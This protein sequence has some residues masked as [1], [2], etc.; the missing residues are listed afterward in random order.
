MLR[1]HIHACPCACF[2]SPVGRSIGLCTAA[3]ADDAVPRV[4]AAGWCGVEPW[5]AAAGEPVLGEAERC[6]RARA[7]LGRRRRHQPVCMR[8]EVLV[9]SHRLSGQR[10][11]KGWT[12]SPRHYLH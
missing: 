3:V 2:R 9:L 4:A 10:P 8:L 11:C 5:V 6:E 12:K 7:A 1:A